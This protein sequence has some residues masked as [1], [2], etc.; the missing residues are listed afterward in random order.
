MTFRA[1]TETQLSS[2]A[3]VPVKISNRAIVVLG[4]NQHRVVLSDESPAGVADLLARAFEA[5]AT[6]DL[7]PDERLAVRTR[8]AEAVDS[9][10]PIDYLPVPPP[11]SVE[12][13]AA[14]RRDAGITGALPGAGVRA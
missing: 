6:A 7:T 2:C 8:M 11:P 12:D 4:D 14:M 3:D 13:I 5:L 1:Y 10:Q 9:V